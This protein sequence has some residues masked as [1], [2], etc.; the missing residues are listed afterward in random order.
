MSTDRADYAFKIVLIGDSGVGKS[1]VLLQFS[2][3]YFADD[4]QS[5]VGVDF[6]EKIIDID[7]S[8]KQKRIKLTVWDTAGQERFR[9]LTSAYYRGAQGMIFVYD[10]TKKQ[11]FDNIDT[12]L[13]ES[14]NYSTDTDNNIIKLLVGN[15]VDMPRVVSREEASEFAES[16]GMLFMEAS[17]KTQ[18]GTAQVFA[19]IAQKILENPFLLNI[20]LER[21]QL[22]ASS[23]DGPCC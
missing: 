12:W 18:V 6:K 3:G 7:Q 21:A 15:K 13:A 16:R 20:Q 8:G 2:D 22:G 19:E 4:M 11:S 10:V 23:S 14:E 9:T 17:A 1:S 5:T